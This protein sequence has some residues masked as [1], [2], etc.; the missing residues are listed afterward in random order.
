MDSLHIDIALPR[1]AFD[2]ELELTL[3]A[4]VL[5]VAGPSGAGK[6][7]LLRAIA[8]LE[9]P[10]R[11]TIRLNDEVWFDSERRVNLPPEQRR[12]GLVFQDYALFP[13]LTVR[14][15]IAFGAAAAPDRLIEVF[16]LGRLLDARPDALS[17]GERQRV[18]LARAL[19]TEPRVLLLDEPLAALDP[20]LRDEVRAEL[21]GLISHLDVPTLLV[22]HDFEDAAVLGEAIGII[23]EGN[24]LQVG[25]AAELT[26]APADPFVAGLT[27]ANLV[28][29]SARLVPSG[30]AQIDVGTGA[31]LFSTDR[32]E[33]DV[34]VAVFP[35]EVSVGREA[36]ED[37]ALN[38]VA[39][40]I[41]S[42]VTIGNRA[43][44]A[45]GPV[46]AEI[47]AASVERLGLAQGGRAVAS[48][49]A[50]GTRLI[51]RKR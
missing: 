43:R 8:G 18:A 17:G 27:G 46:V 6:T 49:K 5:A 16:R 22:T 10:V 34:W 38:H 23:V 33:G 3:G 48:F 11:G 25:T 7:S 51:P 29:G 50:A 4:G 35:W 20:A 26:A 2:L 45:V 21:H 28:A 37:S 42:I 13:H 24:L 32:I 15:N 1:R 41:R 14:Q 40:S 39:S 12:V 36:P 19:A 44:V 47:T 30:L 9:Q 31:P